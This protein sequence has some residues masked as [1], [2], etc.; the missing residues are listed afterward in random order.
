MIYPD[1]KKGI[2][3]N[4]SVKVYVMVGL[5]CILIETEKVYQLDD[6]FECGCKKSISYNYFYYFVCVF[7]IFSVV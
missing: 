2:Q 4:M 7:F 3:N 6:T 5:V 1:K